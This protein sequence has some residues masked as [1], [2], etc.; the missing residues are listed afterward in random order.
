MS[1]TNRRVHYVLSTHWD[2][3]W[4]QP[5]QVYRHRLVQLLDKVL[6]GWADEALQGPFQTDGQAIILDDYLEVRPQ[7]RAKITQLVK[8]GK[9]V[10]GPWYVLPDEF[11]VSGESIIRNI[12]LGYKMSRQFGGIPSKAGFMCD[13]FGHNSQMPQI[14]D[15][16]GIKM[17]FLW[18]GTNQYQKRLFHWHGADGTNIPA[19]RF[20]KIGYCDYALEIRKSFQGGCFDSAKTAA[21]IM[22]YIEDEAGKT[23][24]ETM[25]MFDGCDH[26]EWHPQH[27]AVL[28]QLMESVKD[29]QIIHSNLDAYADEILKQA[30]RIGPVMEGEL[31]ET[32]KTQID[33]DQVWLI[34]GVLS[35]RAWLKQD[36]TACQDMLCLWAEPI[37]TAANLVLGE[38]YPQ[39]FL[40]VA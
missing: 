7:L 22:Q 37:S 30:D 28:M 8:E 12:E 20:G 13:I 38:E 27:H 2:R 19:Y 32:G 23:E 16:F 3:E 15:Q 1:S 40:D 31:R 36:N 25:L 26:H 9:F 24:T 14:F 5:F 29:Y 10:V 18:R 4:Y 6:E 34:P 21:D 35:S 39:G 17:A 33:I 11:I